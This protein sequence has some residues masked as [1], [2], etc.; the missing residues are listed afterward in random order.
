M[1]ADALEP[2][3]IQDEEQ[4]RSTATSH[5]DSAIELE[6]SPGTA[7]VESSP[8]PESRFQRD[9]M[10]RLWQNAPDRETGTDAVAE[11]RA[12]KQL[13]PESDGGRWQRFRRGH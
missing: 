2:A 8:E 7:A 5:A 6:T 11:I 9:A 13:Q 10:A 3:P 4:P 1:P 12:R